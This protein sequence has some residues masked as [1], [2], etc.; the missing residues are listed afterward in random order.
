MI[1]NSIEGPWFS[2]SLPLFLRL[3]FGTVKVKMCRMYVVP[4]KW[5]RRSS[6]VKME[7]KIS[8]IAYRRPLE[9][10]RGLRGLG[11]SVWKLRQGSEAANQL[12]TLDQP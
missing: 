11:W 9:R 6:P 2:S 10:W 12:P 4:C 3:E 1:G 7:P 8:A 5:I